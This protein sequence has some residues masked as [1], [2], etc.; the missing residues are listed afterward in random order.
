[1]HLSLND[2]VISRQASSGSG[3]Q[4]APRSTESFLFVFLIRHGV[5]LSVF[6][7]VAYG[8]LLLR[9]RRRRGERSRHCARAFRLPGVLILSATGICV[10]CG[11]CQLTLRGGG[12]EQNGIEEEIFAYGAVSRMVGRRKGPARERVAHGGGRGG[13]RRSSLFSVRGCFRGGFFINYLLE[14]LLDRRT[15]LV[16]STFRDAYVLIICLYK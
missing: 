15:F 2:V 11:G 3:D 4:S 10:R 16:K 6:V 12:T 13:G 5:S 8:A 14:G 9:K 1:M 7:G